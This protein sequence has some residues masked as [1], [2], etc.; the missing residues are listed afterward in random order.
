MNNFSRKFFSHLSFYLTT[1]ALLQEMGLKVKAT[2]IPL[3]SY[4]EPCSQ[5]KIILKNAVLNYFLKKDSGSRPVAV[6][7]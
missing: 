1:K 4:D 6:D 3:L 5:E 2:E 7:L